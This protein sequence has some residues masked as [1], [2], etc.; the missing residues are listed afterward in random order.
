MATT[1]RV[2][3]FI[4]VNLMFDIS[5]Y[6][7]QSGISVGG[8]SIAANITLMIAGAA[9]CAVSFPLSDVGNALYSMCKNLQSKKIGEAWRRRGYLCSK[10][11]VRHIGGNARN[12]TTL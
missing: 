9:S 5:R 4:V 2:G 1:S 8:L 10:D 6:S 12:R 11:G 3:L 7:I